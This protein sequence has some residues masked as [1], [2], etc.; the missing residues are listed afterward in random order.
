MFDV[1]CEIF[2]MHYFNENRLN[3]IQEISIFSIYT[4][5]HRLK[6]AAIFFQNGVLLVKFGRL[7]A[8]T[9]F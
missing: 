4:C 7:L 3:S 9:T 2:R 8:K 6:W 1:G 5:N